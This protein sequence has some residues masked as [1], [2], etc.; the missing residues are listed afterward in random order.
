MITLKKVLPYLK[1]YK[2]QHEN[3]YSLTKLGVFG[4]V[5]RDENTDSSDLDIVVEFSKPNL[6][7]QSGIMQDLKD[8]FKVNV[9]VIALSKNMNQ[10]LLKRIQK[11]VIYV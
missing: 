4:S 3:D 8:E 7:I 5:A 11:D 9:D 1:E 10:K 6:F 2:Q